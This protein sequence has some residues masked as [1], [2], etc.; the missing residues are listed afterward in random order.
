[1]AAI[2]NFFRS[3]QAVVDDGRD[4]PSAPNGIALE[5]RRM[6]V[7]EARAALAEGRAV[8]IDVREEEECKEG[9]LPGA[10]CLPV[11][12]FSSRDRRWRS[13]LKRLPPETEIVLYCSSG[14]R[15]GQVAKGL[16]SRGWRAANAGGLG[17]W[18]RA[19]VTLEH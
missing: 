7:D 15:A 5:P 18:I 12:G 3:K 1:M 14:N 16:A 13:F 6:T 2:W 17:T 11:S 8:L 9:I 19:G 10:M 4:L